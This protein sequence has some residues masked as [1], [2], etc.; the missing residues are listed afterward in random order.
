MKMN[1]AQRSVLDVCNA[2]R[3]GFLQSGDYGH[4]LS[5]FDGPEYYGHN[6]LVRLA[7]RFTRLLVIVDEP[8]DIVNYG[9]ECS[10]PLD[11]YHGSPFWRGENSELIEVLSELASLYGIR[12][13][14][15]VKKEQEEME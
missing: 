14:C 5:H 7:P 12:F 3:I 15:V 1:E 8:G 4:D 6:D 9:I 13:E 10:F 2:M 11:H